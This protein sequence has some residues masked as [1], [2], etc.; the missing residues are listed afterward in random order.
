M[1]HMFRIVCLL[2][3]LAFATCAA[4]QEPRSDLFSQQPGRYQI[5]INPQ[6]RA[7]TFLLDTATGRVWQLVK[8]TDINATAWQIMKRLDSELDL[9][10][11]IG[12]QGIKTKEPEPVSLP[13]IV[14]PIAPKPRSPLKLNSN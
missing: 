8:F 11:L 10:K 13:P 12:E 14:T 3:G 4:A 9:V 1:A 2:A 7:D 6:V 5:V